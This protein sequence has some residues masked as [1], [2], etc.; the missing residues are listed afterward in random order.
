MTQRQHPWVFPPNYQGNI[1]HRS[2]HIHAYCSTSHTHRNMNPR[3]QLNVSMWPVTLSTR[4]FYL[5]VKFHKVSIRN[6]P[7]IVN[8]L[9]VKIWSSTVAL[10]WYEAI[11]RNQGILWDASIERNIQLETEVSSYSST[12]LGPQTPTVIQNRALMCSLPAVSRVPHQP[13]VQNLKPYLCS[14]LKPNRNFPLGGMI[15]ALNYLPKVMSKV[16]SQWS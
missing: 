12:W 3:P 10:S 4:H 7:L 15:R 2:L 6:S 8:S 16:I 11:L 5:E 13:D 14:L 9:M 1:A